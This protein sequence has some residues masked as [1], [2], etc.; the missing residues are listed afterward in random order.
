MNDT[1]LNKNVILKVI[2]GNSI[3]KKTIPNDELTFSSICNKVL[4]F[5][6]D[7]IT[8]NDELSLKYK[9]NGRF[10]YKF[11]AYFQT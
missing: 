4:I 1:D 8:T 11:F 10:L 9:D 3:I 5:F 2:L 7:K 6:S